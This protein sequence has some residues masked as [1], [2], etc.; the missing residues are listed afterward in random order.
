M[1]AS[2]TMSE[3]IFIIDK[4]TQF[5]YFAIILLVGLE[6]VTGN[7]FGAVK[8]LALARRIRLARKEEDWH[9]V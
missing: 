1:T 6:F 8:Y 4:S 5:G 7:K 9:I 2:V 3:P